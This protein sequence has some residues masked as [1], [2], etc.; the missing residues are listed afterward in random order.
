MRSILPLAAVCWLAG[1]AM[2]QTDAPGVTVSMNGATV[3]HRTMVN[4]PVAARQQGVQG[5][6]AVEVKL[7]ANGNVNDAQVVSGPEGLR[8]A[9]L[10][11]VLEWHFTRDAANGTRTIQVSF[12]ASKTAS[13]EATATLS[14]ARRLPT[15]NIA[16][17]AQ[18]SQ[19]HIASIR[20]VGLSDAASAE[21][22]AALPVHEGDEIDNDTLQ[23]AS[24][25][26]KAFDEHLTVRISGMVQT[27]SGGTD[28]TMA[29]VATEA[30]QALAFVSAAP[31]AAGRLQVSGSVQA[32]QLVSNVAPSYPALAK[33][34]G[35]SGVVHLAAVIAKDGTVQELHSLGGPALLIQAAMDAVKQ[36][37]YRPTL[38]S[39]SPVEVETTVDVNFTLNQ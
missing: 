4:Y 20:I 9:V 1:S 15:F 38:Q 39:G 35:V 5:T 22:L 12:D 33:R 25:A 36:W 23:R 34:A 8:K 11:S 37:V 6:V 27:P 18:T 24:Q 14:D 3:M 28:V 26:A 17:G 2:A 21:L 32:A 10:E 30:P 29:I 16:G 13:V 7:D 19:A 31:A